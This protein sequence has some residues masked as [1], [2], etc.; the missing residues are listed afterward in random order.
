M[1]AILRG[2]EVNEPTWFYLSLLLIL[3]V[4]FKFNRLWS[5]RNTDLLLLLSLAPGLLLVRADAGSSVGYVW[6]F[7]VTFLMVVRLLADG[8]FT[9]RPRLEQNLNSAGMAFLCISAVLFQM[10]KVMTVE[11]HQGT[12]ETVRQADELLN[13]QDTSAETEVALSGPAN[14]LLATPVVKMAGGVDVIA[15]RFLAISAHLAISIGLIFVGRWHFSDTR[16]GLAMAT[17]YLLLPVTSF[18]VTKV[19]HLLPAALIVWAFAVYRSP[20]AAGVLIGLACGSLFFAIFLLPIWTAFYWRRGAT[21]F[22]GAV[23]IVACVLLGSLMLTAVDSHSLTKQ[24][25]GSIDWSLLKFEA[26][27]GVG[28]WSLYD[29]AYR[30]PVFAA[31]A[32]LLVTVTIWPFQK[33][34]EHLMAHSTLIVMATQFWYPHQG[35]IYILWYLPLMLMVVFRP[36]LA[37]LPPK[38]PEPVRKAEDLPDPLPRSGLPNSPIRMQFFR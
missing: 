36:R 5:L 14:R 28:F 10:T 20:T 12:V 24:I 13:R 19:N 21:R 1:E 25:I 16:L 31:F 9:R 11:P 4:F 35:G 22:A 18:E 6:L 29:Q 2:Y 7:G 38:P 32:V 34:L 23:A 8:Y 3:A 37:H 15:A 33:N 30:I 27:E 26:G 17:L